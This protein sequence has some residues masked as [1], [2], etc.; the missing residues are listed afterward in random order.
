MEITDKRVS[1]LIIVVC[2]LLFAS[3]NKTETTTSL[4]DWPVVI[5]YLMP[6]QPI[7]VKVYQQKDIT[8]TATYGSPIT[9]L[10]L[11]LSN[12]TQ[13]VTLT[14]NAPGNYAYNNSSFLAAG[15]TYSVKFTYNNMQVSA[16][17]LMP[18]KPGNYTESATSLNLPFTITTTPGVTEVPALTLKWDNPDS[19]YH[20]LVFKNDQDSPFNIHAYMNSA[21]N[22]TLNAKQASFYDVYYRIFNYLGTYSIILYSVNKEYI[23]VL[24]SNANTTSQKLTNPPTNVT[25]G[26]GIFTAMQADTVRLTLTQN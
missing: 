15:K 16:S 21:V 10:T 18:A 5:S 24:S 13:T 9:G 26:Y 4:A 1:Y 14:E 7:N 6:G 11:T 2:A 12:G 23:D 17:T 8:D 19:L 3:C 20:L 25:N 22:F